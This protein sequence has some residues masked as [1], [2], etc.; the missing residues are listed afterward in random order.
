MLI[1]SYDNSSEHTDTCTLDIK[2]VSKLTI[3]NDAVRRVP[4]PDGRPVPRLF[5]ERWYIDV[6][7][8]IPLMYMGEIAGSFMMACF[9]VW[10][11]NSTA[12]FFG[13]NF[14]GAC[15][16]ELGVETYVLASL[17]LIKTILS[18]LVTL[19]LMT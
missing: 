19:N 15:V 12:M 8:W 3:T 7:T 16:A 5:R 14:N 13:A 6:A 9:L 17:I 11:M 2:P 4:G 10:S 18:G 1:Q